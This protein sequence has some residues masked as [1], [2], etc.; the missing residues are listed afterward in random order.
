MAM[1]QDDYPHLRKLVLSAMFLSL[2][3]W[4][5]GDLN[6]RSHPANI[7]VEIPDFPGKT[8]L[9]Q[10]TGRNEHVFFEK[11]AI[12]IAQPM[13]V[14]S[15]IKTVYPLISGA[16]REPTQYHYLRISGQFNTLE[17][18]T[19]EPI[20]T[21]K[22][23]FFIVFILS[24]SK[25]ILA[26]AQDAEQGELAGNFD[27]IISVPEGTASVLVGWTAQNVPFGRLSNLVL[28]PVEIRDF[29]RW[30]VS[31]LAIGWVI[32]LGVLAWELARV[33]S[34]GSVSVVVASIALIVLATGLSA[35]SVNALVSPIIA[36]LGQLGIP[37]EYLN[38]AMIN[39]IG[40]LAMAA[41]MTL[42][43]LSGGPRHSSYISWLLLLCLSVVVATESFQR[44][45]SGRSPSVDD[46]LLGVTGIVF[47]FIVWVVSTNSVRKK[48][49]APQSN[50]KS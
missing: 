6:F 46:L 12:V 40:H 22:S 14:K 19:L 10:V 16:A 32:V 28:K 2:I 35:S 26:M 23:V 30:S 38:T 8:A 44:H 24:N 36:R 20:L 11:N 42:L 49:P 18:S 5:T 31:F 37:S 27:R 33:K 4:V 9:W 47:A 39:N 17:K 34:V 43:A 45:R 25:Q 15:G 21:P 1:R 29:Y 48:H 41:I 7:T 3:T 50:A 13:P